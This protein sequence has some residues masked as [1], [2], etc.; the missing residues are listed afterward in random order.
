MPHDAAPEWDS[1]PDGSKDKI[2][3]ASRLTYGAP[4]KLRLPRLDWTVEG[5]TGCRMRS[6]RSGGS[7]RCTGTPS[8]QSRAKP[9]RTT[10]VTAED[11]A[12]RSQCAAYGDDGG[13]ASGKRT[14]RFR[15][16]TA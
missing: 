16:V 12:A 15:P 5:M 1:K 13:I 4:D 14:R 3:C 11:F 7:T 9:P 10:A 8:R 2:V 6:C